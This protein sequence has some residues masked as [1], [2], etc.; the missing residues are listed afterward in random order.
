MKRTIANIMTG[1]GALL[2]VGAVQADD[3]ADRAASDPRN[4][5][6]SVDDLDGSG[7][8]RD[9]DSYLNERGWVLGFH[10]NNPSGAYI[11][12]GEAT[13][14]VTSD[15]LRYGE[16]RIAAMQ[17]ALANATGEFALSRGRAVTQERF[18][19]IM[20][21]PGALDRLREPTTAQFLRAVEG[22]LRNLATA[23]L[24]RA[25]Q[26]LGV[27]TRGLPQLDHTQRAQL[28][29]DSVTR[30]LTR[31]AVETFQ[32][33]RLLKSFEESGAVG[34]LI[35]YSEGT[36]QLAENIM[37]GN[38][39]A[40]GRGN[41]SDALDQLNGSLSDEQLLLMHGVR[42]LRDAN[43]NPVLVAFGQ[44]APAITRSDSRQRINMAMSAAE[45]NASMRADGALAEFL[46]VFTQID[47]TTVDGITQSITGEVRGDRN[48]EIDAVD[49]VERMNSELRQRSEFDLTGV[50]RVRT[51]RANHPDTGHPYVG[52]VHL[53]SPS[54]EALFSDRPVTS[55]RESVT[56]DG[57]APAVQR[58]RSPE[59]GRED[60]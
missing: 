29:L 31:S 27:D 54:T 53:W 15:H 50:V 52:V 47:E 58:R 16:A 39:T 4:I 1:L 5:F 26:E 49:F 18:V 35:I 7:I 8:I 17:Q 56:E 21:D 24:D 14:A 23:E 48:V 41:S 25:L 38:L 45:R 55:D 6:P 34:V 60:W 32:G 30:E 37:R 2:L 33:I 11:G 12:W 13:I 40:V 9:R 46:N 57:E 22:R 10:D 19:Q 59:F 43:G 51:W 3:A 36:R 44:A 20:R 28:A 42:L